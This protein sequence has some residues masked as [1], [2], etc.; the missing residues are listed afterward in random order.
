MIEKIQKLSFKLTDSDAAAV[1]SS[2]KAL[3]DNACSI[4]KTHCE[5]SGG[6]FLS[7]MFSRKQ[8]L[9]PK[10]SAA[11]HTLSPVAVHERQTMSSYNI[12]KMLNR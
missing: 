3:T 8:C 11:R 1:T 2:C 10:P 12:K 9:L 5:R 7:A 6:M 4:T